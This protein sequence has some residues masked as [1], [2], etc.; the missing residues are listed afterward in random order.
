MTH[1]LKDM[2]PC[3]MCRLDWRSLQSLWKDEFLQ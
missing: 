2:E 3:F 1:D